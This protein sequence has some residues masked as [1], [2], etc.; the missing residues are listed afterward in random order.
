[1]ASTIVVGGGIVGLCTAYYLTE[2]GHKVTLVEKCAIACHSSGKAGGFLTDGD[3]GWHQRTIAPLAKHSFGLH[4]KLAGVF[5]ADAV[6]YRRVCCVGRGPGKVPP[7]LKPSFGMSMGDQSGLAQVSP[8]K[9]T[10]KLEDAI[11]S[12]GCDIVIGKVQGVETEGGAVKAVKVQ[13]E[14]QEETSIPCENL[15]LAMGAWARDAA[16][17]F[18]ESAMPKDTVSHR[19]TSVIWDNSEV[20]KDATMVF[21]SDMF[22]V[23]IYP[24]ADECYANGCPANAPLPDNPLEIE[25]PPQTIEDVKAEATMAVSCLRD[26]KVIRTTAC[27]LP[28]SDD[29]RPVI[30]RVPKVSN[31]FIGCGGGCWGILNGPAMG[32]CLASLVL[33]EEPA[34]DLE[35]FDP[36]RFEK[37]GR[38]FG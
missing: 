8:L 11:K 29:G 9:L 25:P 36:A 7:W 27:F 17:W 2:R 28:G 38:W 26:S 10:A 34:V 4:E 21:V 31:A 23:E 6:G 19:Y 30:G 22:D 32:H 18:P 5:G 15:V 13:K 20:G 16:S 1:M 35:G 3:S 33:G 12:K 14:N 24:R 37:K